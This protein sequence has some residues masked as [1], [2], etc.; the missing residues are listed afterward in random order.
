MTGTAARL[1][2]L[3]R[4]H[5]VGRA[6]AVLLASVGAALAIA[7]A[8]VA[9]APSIAAVLGAWLLIGGVTVLAA[10]SAFRAGRHAAAP[11]VGRLVEAA[12]GGRPGSIVGLVAPTMPEGASAELWTLADGRAVAVVDGAALAVGRLLARGTR[13]S[14][15]AAAGAAALG[16]LLFVAMAP[17]AGRA[18]AFWHPFRTLADTRTPVR[19]VVDKRTVRRGDSVTVTIDVRA[20]TRA[21]LW[22]RGPGEP[23]RAAPVTL[24]ALGHAVRR[25]G[26]LQA[27]LY[28]RASSGGRRSADVVVAV[29]LPAFVAGLAL[30]ARYPSYL[31]RADEPLAPGAD[32]IPIPEGTVILTSGTASVPLARAAW[33]RGDVRA[34]LAVARTAFSG[35][36][37]PRGTGAWL[38]DLATADGAPLEGDTP[39]LRLTV[40]RDSAPVVAVP[41][42]GRDT[43][44][45]LSLRQP[46]VID[47]RD[48]HGLARL[49]V[50]S[51]RVSQTGKVGETVRESLD[52]S[53]AGE[54]AIV[55][56]DLDAERRGLL[57]GDT[58]RL[59]AEAWDNAPTPHVGRSPEIALRLPSL[60][61]LRAA[62]RAATRDATAEADSIA[63]AQRE[64]GRRTGDL[65]QQRSRDETAARRGT[66]AGRESALPFQA[67]ERAQAVAR[68]QEALQARVQELSRAVER[69]ARA[70]QAAGIGDT[71]FQA[72]LREVQELL[73][74]AVTPELEQRLR[75]LQEA[76]AKLDPEATRRALE[77]LAEAQQQLR[78]ELERSQELFRRAAV[79]GTLASL[80]ADAEQLR[81]RQAEWNGDA[82][83]RA[84]SAAAGRQRVLAAAA[85]SLAHAIGRVAKEL[86]EPPGGTAPLAAPERAA[87]DAGSAMR[88]AAQAA[89]LGQA[90]PAAQEGAEAER[91]LAGVPDQ[92]RGQLDSLAE[93]WRGETLAALDRALSETAAMAER[94]RQVSEALHRGE[95]GAP[96]RSRQASVEEGTDVVARHI[97]DAAGKHALVSPQLDAALGYAKRQ[98]A[99][100]RAQ[101]E[102]ADPNA[103]E[104][105]ALAD[106]AVDALN[107]VAVALAQSRK[108]VSGAKSGSG[109]AEAVE[110]LARLARDQQG[111]NG[112]AQGLLPLMGAG[113]AVLEQ[114]RALAAR[115]RA[116][117]EQLER[118][119]AQGISSAAG[120]LAQEARELA[121][122]LEAGRLD[123]RTIE[124]QQRLYHRLLDAGRTLSNEEPDQNKERMSRA[125]TG[126]SVHVPAALKPGATGAGPRLRYPTWD[127]LRGLTPEERRLV[128]DYFRRL[129]APQQ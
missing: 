63:D 128:L 46:L 72:R 119:Q 42:P 44:L 120:P 8:G 5:A 97:R 70:A 101:L 54:R 93:A 26:P 66:E 13:T 65:A 39:E 109:F 23:W 77:R 91:Q 111:L 18:A 30:T 1:R 47:A 64:L 95:A 2:R 55:Q 58:L 115:Q 127:E 114:L 88:R 37:A 99:A 41:V 33:R 43:T 57:P 25:L 73:R 53:G 118:M 126:D 98:M 36:F 68:E 6:A 69:I 24:D 107:V 89:D 19:L 28:V 17:G 96:T 116:L 62:T 86:G 74:R 103:A 108:Q 31:G 80:A 52:V 71:A 61:E 83:S 117:A 15:V 94:Q 67:T 84:D 12:T 129:N 82:V 9:L 85:D 60:E 75:E 14:L 51:W 123:Q 49:E 105:A 90:V 10:R 104:A 50:L 20:A 38:L 7:G 122:Q 35:R 29:T 59:R 21:T 4:P 16:A 11:A 40:V 125:A 48:D 87:R 78:A 100:A 3:G 79:E 92:L 45:P 112:Q 22:T 34:P 32:T 113:Q 124:R 102:E 56:G 121:R 81:R 76:L 27:D 106:D 110:R